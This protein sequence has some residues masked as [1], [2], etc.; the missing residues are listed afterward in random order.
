[1]DAMKTNP[2]CPICDMPLDYFETSR[3]GTLLHTTQRYLERCH[4][5]L[6]IGRVGRD[7]ALENWVAIGGELVD[8]G[9]VDWA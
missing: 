8:D 2:V 1:M 7:A 5:A 4:F 6:D 3:Y 9:E